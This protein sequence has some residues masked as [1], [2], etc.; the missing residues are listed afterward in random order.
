MVWGEWG[1]SFLRKVEDDIGVQVIETVV[2]KDA[3][4]TYALT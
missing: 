2:N 4:G 1:V 3:C